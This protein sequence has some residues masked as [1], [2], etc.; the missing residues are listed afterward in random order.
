MHMNANRR[1]WRIPVDPATPDRSLSFP[2]REVK[3]QP[4]DPLG[5]L[6]FLAVKKELGGPLFFVPS[7]GGPDSIDEGCYHLLKAQNFG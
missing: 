3:K 7:G 4:Q 5:F 1:K 2:K 6:G